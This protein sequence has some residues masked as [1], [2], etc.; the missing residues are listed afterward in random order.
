MLCCSNVKRN[1]DTYLVSEMCSLLLFFGVVCGYTSV[2][3]NFIMNV[4]FCIFRVCCA[5]ESLWLAAFLDANCFLRINEGFMTFSVLQVHEFKDHDRVIWCCASAQR[6][7]IDTEKNIGTS[8]TLG[9]CKIGARQTSVNSNL[10]TYW[11]RWLTRSLKTMRQISIWFINVLAW[12]IGTLD[13]CDWLFSKLIIFLH[14]DII[15]R[16]DVTT[17]VRTI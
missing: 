5:C 6:I 16:L 1:S 2:G 3:S 15:M 17:L 8:T 4:L 12:M 14:N 10:C 13:N 7:S 9:T 11:E